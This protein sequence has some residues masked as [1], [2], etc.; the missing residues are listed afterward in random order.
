MFLDIYELSPCNWEE[1]PNPRNIKYNKFSENDFL[2]HLLEKEPSN[3]LSA[4]RTKMESLTTNSWF[5][6]LGDTIIKI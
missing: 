3:N 6:S 1:T 4:E 5:F 2:Y